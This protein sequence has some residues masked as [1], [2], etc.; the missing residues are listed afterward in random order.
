[1]TIRTS[2][3]TPTTSPAINGQLTGGSVS[4]LP[5][6]VSL[7]NGVAG[8]LF[9]GRPLLKVPL[10]DCTVPVGGG[11][12][13]GDVVGTAEVTWVVEAMLS[14]TSTPLG[15][16]KKSSEEVGLGCMDEC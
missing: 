16:E 11:D 4:S 1:M 3:I 5:K 15:D 8:I 14:S 12:I 6:D 10:S 7:S 13:L 9:T 2:R